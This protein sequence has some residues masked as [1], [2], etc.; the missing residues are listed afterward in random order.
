MWTGAPRRRASLARIGAFL[1]ALVTCLVVAAA[2]WG[3]AGTVQ[4]TVP[5]RLPAFNQGL[6]YEVTLKGN[7]APGQHMTASDFQ[8]SV[9][10]L[11]SL[12]SHIRAAYHRSQPATAGGRWTEH[13]FFAVNYP[14]T[15]SARDAS[16]PGG[17]PPENIDMLIR[18]ITAP[19]SGPLNSSVIIRALDCAA[20]ERV[21]SWQG[22]PGT[23]WASSGGHIGAETGKHCWAGA[24]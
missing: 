1:F 24:H 22:I 12:P 2:G 16:L 4:R 3:V 6:F 7:A 11:S 14:K 10:N 8:V 5:L 21:K 13:L 17:R 18:I 19:H 23:P 20:G 15:L 9:A